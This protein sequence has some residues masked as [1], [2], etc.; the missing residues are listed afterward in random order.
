MY[1]KSVK[2]FLKYDI[3]TLENL[4]NRDIEILKH[5]RSLFFI[6]PY[7]TLFNKIFEKNK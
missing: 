4:F 2:E 3:E 7:D 5:N 6:K 1:I